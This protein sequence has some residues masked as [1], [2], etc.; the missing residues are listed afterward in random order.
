MRRVE[1]P[2]ATFG[3]WKLGPNPISRVRQRTLHTHTLVRQQWHAAELG[4]DRTGTLQRHCSERKRR[5]GA[6]AQL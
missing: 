5:D 1:R 6:E 3:W 2:K 4:S